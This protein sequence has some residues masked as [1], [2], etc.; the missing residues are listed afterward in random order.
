MQLALKV[1]ANYYEN[2]YYYCWCWCWCWCCYYYYYCYYCYCYYYYYYCYYCY[3]CC[4]YYYYDYYD[5]YDYYHY[6]Y[7]CYYYYS[8][9]YYYY[10]P[11]K[12]PCMHALSELTGLRVMV[13]GSCAIRTASHHP[14]HL[15]ALGVEGPHLQDICLSKARRLWHLQGFVRGSGQATL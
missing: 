15:D 8:Y 3:Y 13:S 9:Y 10:H 7:Y 11:V 14:E 4:Y 5:Y 12:Y 2:D 6:Y 1:R